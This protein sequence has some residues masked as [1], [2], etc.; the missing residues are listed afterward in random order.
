MPIFDKEN[1]TYFLPEAEQMK[2]EVE[3]PEPGI[4][5]VLKDIEDK[6]ELMDASPRPRPNPDP[7][8]IPDIE[9]EVGEDDIEFTL[10]RIEAF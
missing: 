8:I 1:N 7:S 3:K 2:I 10:R 6:L 9:Q 4:M 5:D